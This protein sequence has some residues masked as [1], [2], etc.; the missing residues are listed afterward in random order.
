MR[1]L[2]LALA[3]L[4]CG[5][6]DPSIDED[7]SCQQAEDNLVGLDCGVPERVCELE[8]DLPGLLDVPCLAG[9]E[10]CQQAD[11]CSE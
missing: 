8:A 11:T 4:A 6:V 5:P 2:L 3:L 9:A 7:A 10:S 1:P